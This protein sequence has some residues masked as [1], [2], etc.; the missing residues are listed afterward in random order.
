MN[1]TPTAESSLRRSLN[2]RS[3]LRRAG[4]MAALSPAASYFVS[5]KESASA[6]VSI[7]AGTELDLAILNFALNLE[8]LE[9]EY[10]TRGTT[11][12]GLAAAGTRTTGAGSAGTVVSKANP[13]VPFV[14]KPLAAY[15]LEIAQDERNHI[16]FIQ[17]TITAL[18]GTP[19]DEPNIDLL[20]S[21]N[22]VAANAGIASTFDP[23]A[24]EVSF[25]LGAFSLTDVGVTAYL[26]AGPLITN[27]AVLKGA[28]GILAVEAYHD[29]TLRL[30][31]FQAGTDAQIKAQKVSDLRDSLDDGGKRDKDQG[32]ANADGS[33]NIVP[34]DAH[35]LA[36]PR[37][38]RQV[39]N[40]VYGAT[41]ATSG[42]FFPSGVNG[43]IK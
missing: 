31:I 1:D 27:K 13:L 23:F 8:F 9:G 18:G 7:P 35:S 32:V 20:N 42:G 28:S 2:R 15:A 24:D 3:F 4:M 30:S 6:A 16:A 19:I 39:L 22:T 34:T 41:K 25:Y 37:S 10:Y 17:E 36:F 33:P 21:F 26:G 43:L 14:S 11:G 29:A 5:N 38:T 40:I 12:A